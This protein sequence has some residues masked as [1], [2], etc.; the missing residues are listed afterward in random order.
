MLEL[1]KVQLRLQEAAV[2]NDKHRTFLQTWETDVRPHQ[3]E[4]LRA[5][6][7]GHAYAK[8]TIQT[9]FWLNGGALVAFPAFAKLAGAQFS[10][11]LP[12]ALLGI[13]CFVLGLVLIAITSLAAYQACA[14]DSGMTSVRRE[15]TKLI[16]QQGRDPQERSEKWGEKIGA[17][18]AAIGAE[19]ERS[20]RWQ[21]TAI[22]CGIASLAAFVAGTLFAASVLAG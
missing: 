4:F 8:M 16:L 17:A 1:Q 5:V 12:R 14:A 19:Q 9:I 3:E 21:R 7:M 11:H 6:D 13:G 10:A 22:R 2:E 15:H 20:Q 18:L